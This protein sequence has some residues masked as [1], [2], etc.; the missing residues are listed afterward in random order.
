MKLS[1][2]ESLLAGAKVVIVNLRPPEPFPSRIWHS[3]FALATTIH[4][5]FDL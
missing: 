2:I 1:Y 4:P 5:S 3:V